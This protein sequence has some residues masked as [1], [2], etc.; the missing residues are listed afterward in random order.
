MI[1]KIPLITLV[2]ASNSFNL[3]PIQGIM[4]DRYGELLGNWFTGF[5]SSLF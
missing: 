3:N 2:S 4:V 1:A 5:I